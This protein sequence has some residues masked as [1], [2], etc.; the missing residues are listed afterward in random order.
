MP[1]LSPRQWLLLILAIIG[2]AMVFVFQDFDFTHFK[3]IPDQY[4][5]GH[6]A[7]GDGW[8]FAINKGMRFLL[9]DLFSLLFIY[10]LFNNKGY[11]Q[12]ALLVMAFGLLIL[13]PTYLILAIYYQE[14]GFHLLMF[15]HRITMNPWLMLLLVPAFLYQA[16]KKS[17]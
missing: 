13:L 14:E 4:A 7:E 8:R 17:E 9:N 6:I 1:K 16:N 15:L 11:S 2:W 3:F 12:L 10:A 5:Q